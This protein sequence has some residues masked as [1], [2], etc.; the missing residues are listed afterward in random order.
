MCW[1]AWTGDGTG[2]V[3]DVKPAGR[4]RSA[5]RQFGLTREACSAAGWE[6]VVFT[7][8]AE[9]LASN[10]RWLTGDHQDRFA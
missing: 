2:R 5:E 8:L 10:L 9:P 6:Y 3:V 4:V 7:G 1:R